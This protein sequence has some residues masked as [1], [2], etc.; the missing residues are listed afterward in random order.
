MEFSI[1]DHCVLCLIIQCQ[2]SVNLLKNQVQKIHP[3]RNIV[4]SYKNFEL[5]FEKKVHTCANIIWFSVTSVAELYLKFGFSEKAT[6]FE[7]K[8]F[9]VLL[10]RGSC[11]VRATAY[12]SKSQRSFFKTNVV[13]S[14]YTNFTHTIYMRQNYL[15]PSSIWIRK[16]KKKTL[17]LEHRFAVRDFYFGLYFLGTCQSVN[18]SNVYFRI[19]DY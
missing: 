6:K 4:I 10:T 18:L 8:N 17:L 14:Y 3:S 5:T 11:S 15:E 2:I 1:L 12:L 16:K 13:K 19:C 9:V 7:K